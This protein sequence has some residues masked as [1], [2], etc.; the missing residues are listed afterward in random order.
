MRVGALNV[1]YRSSGAGEPIVLLHGFPT[2]SYDWRRFLGPLSKYGKVIAPDLFGFGY[3]DSPKNGDYTLTGYSSFL[4]DF[5]SVMGIERFS[6]VGHDWGGFIALRYAI[7]NPGSVSHLVI[8]DAILYTDWV[9]HE[10]TSPNY[11][12]IR[13]MVRHGLFRTMARLLVN[14]KSIKQMIAP[15]PEKFVSEEDLE[16]YVF[17]FKHSFNALKL[18]SDAHLEWVEKNTP[19]LSAKLKELVVPTQ[20]IWG[21][22]DPYIPPTTPLRLH[23]DIRGS[24]L[25][26]LERTG[27]WPFEEMPEQVIEL[28]ASF[29]KRPDIV[30]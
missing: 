10:R 21:K 17:F 26:I 19:E 15:G 6:L 29:L 1:F 23:N 20:I 14:K 27:H 12:V 13:R 30:A 16:H 4:R 22:D 3:S 18:Y 25:H 8:M 5:L 24:A 28:V 11:A 2:S 7:E 9:Q